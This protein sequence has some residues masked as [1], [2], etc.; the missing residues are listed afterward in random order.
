MV[1]ACEKFLTDDLKTNGLMDP[2]NFLQNVL[3]D[4]LKSQV[5]TI[6]AVPYF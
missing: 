2:I 1:F 3:L 5:P 4:I 6:T